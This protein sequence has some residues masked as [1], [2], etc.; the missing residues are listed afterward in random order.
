MY[1]CAYRHRWKG[2]EN[3][4][5]LCLHEVGQ[6]G[7]GWRFFRIEHR[8]F[9]VFNIRECGAVAA[10]NDPKELTRA[11]VDWVRCNP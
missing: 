1:V 9:E 7:L 11:G 10:Q 6:R 8:N 2:Y 3:F 4:P 5:N